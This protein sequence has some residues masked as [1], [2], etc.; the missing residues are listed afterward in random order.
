MGTDASNWV[1]YYFQCTSGG[2]HDSGWVS[3]NK[4]TDVGLTPG[5]TY[6]Y[7]VKMRDKNGNTT[8]ASS[9]AGAT[10][11]SSTIGT[12]SFAY[13]PGRLSPTARSP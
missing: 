10:T 8:A 2:G 1:E 12:A 6:T 3:F 11:Q 7:T 9:P 5:A 4:Y 13:G